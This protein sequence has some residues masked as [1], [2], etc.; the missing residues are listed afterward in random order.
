MKVQ[1]VPY[2]LLIHTFILYSVQNLQ[3]MTVEIGEKIKGMGGGWSL[4]ESTIFL[5]VGEGGS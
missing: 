4:S 1:H 3:K 2:S 5:E